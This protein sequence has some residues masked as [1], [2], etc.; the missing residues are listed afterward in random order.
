MSGIVVNSSFSIVDLAGSCT[1]SVGS[2][3][4]CRE[5]HAE[6]RSRLSG[7]A[8]GRRRVELGRRWAQELPAASARVHTA[9]HIPSE[10]GELV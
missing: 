5:T 6:H 10:A 4:P 1:P 2:I 7:V 9:D 8:S 3:T